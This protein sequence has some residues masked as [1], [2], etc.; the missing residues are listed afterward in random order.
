MIKFID[1]IVNRVGLGIS[2]LLLPLMLITTI[3]VIA[4][5]I[6]NRPTIWAWDINMQIFS[7]LVAIGGSYGLRHNAH[8]KVDVFVMNLN[9]RI[10]A[11]LDLI[12][13]L[14]FFFTMVV[15]LY[16]STKAAIESVKIK[17]TMSTVWAPPFYHIMVIIPIG[18]LLFLIQGIAIHI[19]NFMLVIKKDG[20]R[21][22]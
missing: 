19:R 7:L 1:D 16:E 17:E 11:I 22:Q 18:A 21:D 4:R 3:E 8:V 5:Y 14:L 20:L 6:F 2:F 10:R 12:T 9:P 13:S 15:F